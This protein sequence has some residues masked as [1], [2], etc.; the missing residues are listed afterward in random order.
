[1]Q[2]RRV[3]STHFKR[4]RIATAILPRAVAQQVQL[5][6]TSCIAAGTRTPAGIVA[7]YPDPADG[8]ALLFVG[9][10]E[11]REMHVSSLSVPSAA[12]QS[13]NHLECRV[14][15]T[16]RGRAAQRAVGVA[17]GQARDLSSGDNG[18]RRVTGEWLSSAMAVLSYRTC[19]YVF[20]K[21]L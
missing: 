18:V 17:R 5:Q 15:G 3:V 4:H 12:S 19:H 21:N 9:L 14:W 20:K 6:A 2:W 11:L 16:R 8:Q 1:V 7:S 10:S 13:V